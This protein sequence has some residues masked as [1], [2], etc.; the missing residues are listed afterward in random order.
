[1]KN[2]DYD[3][4]AQQ[5]EGHL[6]A[7]SIATTS[8]SRASCARST[9]WR[10]ASLTPGL[11]LGGGRIGPEL[12]PYDIFHT[13]VSRRPRWIT[14]R[15]RA[16]GI[17]NTEQKVQGATISSDLGNYGWKLPSSK[18]G[19]GVALGVE[20]RTEKLKSEFD[21]EFSSATWPRRRPTNRASA[22]NTPS[23][24]TSPSCAF[25][26]WKAVPAPTC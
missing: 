11:P 21:V 1:V 12:R 10:T 4:Y 7:R 18:S 14:S 17:R 22:A 13:V 26:S 15:R 3:V 20:R 16:F 9:S 19:I 2:W 5:L 8:R 25:R 23:R 6:S 24:T